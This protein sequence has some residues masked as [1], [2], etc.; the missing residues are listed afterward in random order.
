M[1]ET[2][3]KVPP[4]MKAF[5]DALPLPPASQWTP[6]DDILKLPSVAEI[7]SAGDV[8]AIVNAKLIESKEEGSELFVR[9][10]IFG[11][12]IRDVY[13]GFPLKRGGGY[14]E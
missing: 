9:L 13:H 6:L 2:T 10:T 8:N 4:G 11:S 1:T 5:L 14:R 3:K 7:C 12:I